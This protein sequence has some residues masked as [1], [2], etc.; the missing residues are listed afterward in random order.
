MDQRRI[1]VSA[2]RAKYAMIIIGNGDTMGSNEVWDGYLKFIESKKLYF[3]INSLDEEEMIL[4]KLNKKDFF[5]QQSI[6]RR[7]YQPN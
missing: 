3:E 2:T 1:N 6:R 7:F 4:S 5:N